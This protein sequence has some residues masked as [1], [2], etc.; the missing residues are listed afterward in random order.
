MS[1]TTQEEKEQFVLNAI[2]ALRSDKSKGIHVRFSGFNDA[3]RAKFGEDPRAFTERMAKEGKVFIGPAR[4]GAMMYLP[5]EEPGTLSPEEVLA[6][7]ES[8]SS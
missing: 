1:S 8:F 6:K 7:I 4:K 2:L 3:F 5:G